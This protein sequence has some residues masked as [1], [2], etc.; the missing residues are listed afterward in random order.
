MCGVWFCMLAAEEEMK[1][2]VGQTSMAAGDPWKIGFKATWNIV[3]QAPSK[4]QGRERKGE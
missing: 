3:L 2:V 4:K 1:T